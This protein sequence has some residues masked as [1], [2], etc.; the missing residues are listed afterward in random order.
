MKLWT[1]F[2][3][4]FQSWKICEYPWF[5]IA[6]SLCQTILIKIYS[7][8]D[9][10]SISHH[11]LAQRVLKFTRGILSHKYKTCQYEEKKKW[12]N[13]K[14]NVFSGHKCLNLYIHISQFCWLSFDKCTR[15][16][17]LKLSKKNVCYVNTE[18]NRDQPYQINWNT[19][20][21]SSAFILG[22][23]F[24]THISFGV[25]LLTRADFLFSFVQTYGLYCRS[26]LAQFSQPDFNS[27]FC[28]LRNK[29]LNQNKKKV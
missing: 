10:K 3:F 23:G 25:S 7:F 19:F 27:T 5:W 12:E 2:V 17:F 15:R 29:S 4:I 21:L 11:P 20:L 18:P 1:R 22:G 13:A 26:G 14:E 16:H 28:R 24:F 8:L 6:V 9:F